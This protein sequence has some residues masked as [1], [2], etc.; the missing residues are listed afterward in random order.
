[1]ATL[2]STPSQLQAMN[3][4]LTGSYELANDIDMKG[5]TFVPIGESTAF[6]GN[7]DG[8]GFVIS[9]LKIISELNGIGLFGLINNP[10]TVI[11][12]LGL[13]DCDISGSDLY[14]WVGG[15]IGTLNSG[16]IENCYST[17]KITGKYMVGG[18]V[19][20]HVNNG[21]VKNCW[22]SAT[23]TGLS[24]VGG[25]IGYVSTTTA[26][27]QNSYATGHSE[28]TE[29]GTTFPSG[30]LIGDNRGTT[31]VTNSYWDKETS[32]VTI[33]EGGTS[34]TTLEMKTQSTF[35]SWDFDTI[36]GFNNDYPYL[37]VFGIPEIPVIAQDVTVNLSSHS[38]LISSVLEHS[39]RKVSISLSHSSIVSSESSRTLQ[40]MKNVTSHIDEIVSNVT[41]LQNA[42]IKDYQ[43]TSYLEG[44]GSN[45]S[46][47][48]R[49]VRTV[50]SEINPIQIITDI[51]IPFEVAKP[52]FAT[53]Y[54]IEN[55]TNLQA[56]N[57]YT[58]MD[59]V[60]NKSNGSTLNHQ[61]NMTL[62]ENVT[63]TSVI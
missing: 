10:S 45:V 61:S 20:R 6:T 29:V 19:G 4:N 48:V 55:P 49:T 30:G 53:V 41:T 9:N 33:S 5:I 42:N 7:L 59:R 21:L 31:N 22:S 44:I 18:L 34:K 54:L 56:T 12:N 51:E 13:I 58:T 26:L 62:Q 17:G 1:M 23:V 50:T 16:T 37:K 40:L 11:K 57:N 32:G 60:E 39:K 46:R 63:E 25:L 35:V 3:N 43:V 14:N 38:E 8:K 28:A 27:V 36:W 52:V 24:R 15:I 2:I 47:V